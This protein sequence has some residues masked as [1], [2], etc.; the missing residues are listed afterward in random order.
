MD[1]WFY[2]QQGQRQGPMSEEQLRGLASA[3]QLK[4]TDLVWKK[5]MAEWTKASQMF[6]LPPPDLNGPTVPMQTAQ[7]DSK[8]KGVNAQPGIVSRMTPR[9]REL[10]THIVSFWKKPIF[11]RVWLV[12]G[13]SIG[14]VLF[15]VSPIL[16]Y[17]GD[18][19]RREASE[20]AKTYGRMA[21]MGSQ[22]NIETIEG[23]AKEAIGFGYDKGFTKLAFRGNDLFYKPPVTETEANRLGRYLL[24]SGWWKANVSHE[25]AITK[26]GT[27]YEYRLRSKPGAEQDLEVIRAFEAFSDELSEK[28]FDDAPVDIHLCNS[29]SD[30]IRVVNPHHK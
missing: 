23:R 26:S 16:W 22:R 25:I 17:S 6:P 28:V 21:Q 27:T 30:T 18:R 12:L 24:A 1:Q 29:M 5:G 9:S 13:V 2:A 10:T 19:E 11:T 14:V 8:A 20:S 15:V 4:P 7:V 3:G